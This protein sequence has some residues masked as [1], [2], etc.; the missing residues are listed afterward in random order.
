[1]KRRLFIKFATVSGLFFSTNICIAKTISPKSLNLLDEVYEI[2][3]PKTSTMPSAR[4]FGALN[5]LV[6]NINHKSFDNYDKNLVLQ[7]A[8]DFHSSFPEFLNLN[9]DK[10]RKII[11]DIVNT[12]DYAQSWISKLIYYGIEAMLGDPIYGGNTN[13]IGWKSINHS[14]GYP[15]P[16]FKYGQKI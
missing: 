4:E 6:E 7:G 2:L 8:L 3:F 10:K 5:F 15:R 12:N 13:Q 11:E 14:I 9:K 1:M 16:K